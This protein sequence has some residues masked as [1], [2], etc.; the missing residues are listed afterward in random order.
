LTALKGEAHATRL[1]RGID[2]DLYHPKRRDRGWLKQTFGIDEDRFVLL[3][4]GRADESKKVM[5]AARAARRLLDLGRPIH[6]FL[7]GDGAD[8]DA[9]RSL[10]GPNATLPGFLEPDILAAVYASADV[11]VFP[12]QSEIMPNVVMEAKASA[13]PPIVDAGDASAQLVA[14]PGLDGLLVQDETP[15]A[16]ATTID[17]LIQTPSCHLAMRQ[18]A[19]T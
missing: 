8:R 18:A 2:K 12:S 4:V 11:L 1:R 14:R 5:T 9:V 19:R 13:L 7:A 6:F 15:A 17:Q 10:L 3:F 16:W